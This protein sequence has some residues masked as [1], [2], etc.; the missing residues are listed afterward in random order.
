MKLFAAGLALAIVPLS[1]AS[2]TPS[3]TEQLRDWLPYQN[4]QFELLF[5]YYPDGGE[6]GEPLDSVD[7]HRAV[8]KAGPT[9]TILSVKAPYDRQSRVIG[10]YNPHNWKSWF[11]KYE[12]NAG[13]FIFDLGRGLKW[14]RTSGSGPSYHRDPSEYGLEFGQGDL[15]I[16]PDLRSGSARNH[17]FGAKNQSSSLLGQSGPFQIESI[18]V[19]RV[20]R[21]P[22]PL[23]D[24]PMVWNVTPPEISPPPPSV[25]VPDDSHLVF[26][27]LIVTISLALFKRLKR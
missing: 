24:Q 1:P 10:G 4:A 2:P 21:G 16:N 9:V 26:E 15:V 6:D 18:E 3:Q 23:S 11:G 19:Y 5:G 17:S 20:R 22:A 7:L 12:S 13:R 27:L 25:V 8:D 14:E